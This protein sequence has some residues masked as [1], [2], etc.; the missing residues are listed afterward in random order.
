[1]TQTRLRGLYAITDEQLIPEA[2]FAATI[3]QALRGGTSIIQYRDK[4]NDAGKRRQQA[5][6]LR[7]LCN[8]YTALLVINDDIDLAKAVGADGVHLGEDDAAIEQARSALGDDAIIGIS[9]YNLLERAVE[10]Q[11]AGADYV[12]FGAMFA[13][14]TKP[15]ARSAS[16]DL[17]HQ[18]KARLDI[19]V[20]AIGGI[21]GHNAAGVIV[22]GADMVALISGLFAA[23][24]ITQT[25]EHIAGLFD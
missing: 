14:P 2:D 19:P 5:S 23:D 25:A 16:Y 4:S 15:L 11:A 24:D 1:V 17:I 10:A 8:R 6:V 12:A 21:D 3:E 22:S 9:C 20:C 7:E 13:S 18:A